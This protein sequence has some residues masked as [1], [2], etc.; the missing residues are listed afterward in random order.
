MSFRPALLCLLRLTILVG[1]VLGSAPAVQA[2][3]LEE[4]LA[5]TPA[6]E[7]FQGA[8][9][10][11]APQGSPAIVPVMRGTETLGYAYLASDFT[12]STGYSGK[13]IHILV[14]IDPKGAGRATGS[15]WGAG[16]MYCSG[17]W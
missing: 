12:A 2:A 13:P 10:Y 1:A 11:G 8:D 5:R 17:N 3:T 14:G 16:S 7:L 6:S 4:A 9:A 15:G